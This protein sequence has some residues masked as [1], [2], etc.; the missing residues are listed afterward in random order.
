MRNG[1]AHFV[2]KVLARRKSLPGKFWVFAPLGGGGAGTEL[3]H[4]SR[5]GWV[6]GE[7]VAQWLG[8][9]L[10]RLLLVW[11]SDLIISTGPHRRA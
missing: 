11:P 9:T 3:G 5:P 10:D 8:R 6:T 2:Q 7:S 4:L 1:F